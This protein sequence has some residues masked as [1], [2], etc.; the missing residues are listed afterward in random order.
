MDGDERQ[1]N[2]REWTRMEDHGCEHKPIVHKNQDRQIKAVCFVRGTPDKPK[3][4]SIAAFRREI[5][6]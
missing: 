6:N 4:L 3:R 2:N 5:N 1:K